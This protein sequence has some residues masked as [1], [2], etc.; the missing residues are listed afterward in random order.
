MEYSDSVEKSAE[1]LRLA[2]PL[3]SRQAAALHPVSYAVWYEYVAGRNAALKAQIDDVMRGGGVLD[4]RATLELFRKHIAELDHE[5]AQRVREGFQK[6]MAD[7]SHSATQAGDHAHQFGGVLDQLSEGLAEAAPGVGLG[8]GIDTLR[9]HTR[10]MQGA[11]ATLK[12]RLD[13]S[14]R[15]IEQLRQEVAKARE[16]ALADVLTGLAN[17]R[18]FDLALGARLAGREPGEAGPSL[19]IVDIDHFKR[20]NDS[21]GHLF[22]DKVIRAVAQILK[23]NVKG[24]DTAARY[25]GEEFVILLP[26][27]PLDGARFVAEKIRATV[28]KCR[29]KRAD[30]QE[31]VATVTISLGAACYR[32]GESAS[33]FVAR[34]DKALYTSKNR[35]RNRV[36]LDGSS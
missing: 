10:T 28:E 13:D 29:I 24:K 17:R 25:G 7:M 3:M 11:V 18:G 14:R 5:L 33:D 27:T 16:D 2:L 31:T 4:E 36:T 19:L 6:V 32:G 21:Y 35:G 20:V 26:D 23:D 30:S 8:E 34:A 1:Y 15:E 22:G 9:E 12:G